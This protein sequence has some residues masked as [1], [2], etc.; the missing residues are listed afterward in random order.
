[1]EVYLDNSAT[2]PVSEVVLN[3]MEAYW[4]QQFANPSSPHHLGVEAENTLAQCREF[5]AQLLNVNPRELYFTSSGTEA[6]NLAILGYCLNQRKP[7]HIITTSIEHLSVLK[8]IEYLVNNHGWTA[9]ELSV[10]DQ[11]IIDL[12]QL[13]QAIRPETALIST[14]LVNNEIG[15]VQPI[16]QIS[17]VIL[18]V[19]QRQER[20]YNPIIFHVDGCQALGKV[21]FQ[22]NRDRIDLLSLSGHKIFGPKGSGLLYCRN[23]IRLQPLL[24]GGGQEAGLR[25][26]TENLPAIMGFTKAIQIILTDI[27]DQIKKMSQLKQQMINKLEHISNTNLNARAAHAPHIINIRFAGVKGE[28]LVHFLEQRG[29]YVSMGAACSSYKNSISHVLQAIG[30]TEEEATTS[31]RI[32]LSPYLTKSEVNYAAQAITESVTE[33]RSIYR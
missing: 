11:G 28:V 8:P 23:T 31:I 32:S 20:K 6:N 26:G 21:P 25:S 12:E 9:T 3:K 27:T 17:N 16:N 14:M 2:T 1:M 33:I 4:S 18:E 10:N 30:L 29:I 7:G 5:I 22:I 24:Y 13:K 15:S 19:N